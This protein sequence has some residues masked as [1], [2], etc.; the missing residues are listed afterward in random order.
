[1]L[2]TALNWSAWDVHGRGEGLLAATEMCN[3][4]GHCRK[5]DTGTMCP[6][7]RA[8]GDEQHLTRGRANSLRLA[9][10]GQLGANA[11][12]DAAMHEAMSLCV[13]CKGCKRECP[14]GVDMARMKIEFMHHYTRQHGLTARQNLVAYLPRRAPALS[15]L[16]RLLNLRDKIP[17]AAFVSEKLMG[18]SARRSLPKW[19]ANVDESWRS[20]N[21]AGREIVLFVDTFNRWFEPENVTAALRVLNAGGYRV[22]IAAS[23]AHARP[24][25]CGRTFLSAGLVDE[26]RIEARRLLAALKPMAEKGVPIVGL[27]PSCLLTLR[28]EYS[29]MLEDAELGAVPQQALM[30]EEFLI[31]EHRAG[32]LHLPLR[33]ITGKKA[34]LHGH[35][36]QKAF[37]IMTDVEQVLKL[38][39]DLQVET[40]P[41]SCC[42]MA[43]DFGYHAEHF[44]LSME[45][46]EA[47][48]L[49]Q[50]RKAAAEDWIVA[51]GTSCRHQI[52]DGA[53]REAVHVAKLLSAALPAPLLG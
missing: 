18:I 22:H 34:L 17:G 21:A 3:N 12:T 43:G 42:G 28:D 29:V 27:E 44:D 53:Q 9:L 8:T 10:S 49:P 41:S 52:K 7:Y 39:P 14:T 13:S 37:G 20:T 25:C 24:L 33:P 11:I 6:S 40:I 31:R 15:K 35:C 1:M 30:F 36:H 51:D 19:H 23:E 32:R 5:F 47:G 16:S 38:I 26:A 2:K 48:L 50:V 46:A 4:N 45:M